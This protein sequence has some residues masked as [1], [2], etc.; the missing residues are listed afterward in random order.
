M[1][2][3]IV[4]TGLKARGY[5]DGRYVGEEK[6]EAG[7]GREDVLRGRK[8]RGKAAGPGT[9][10]GAGRGKKR[11][12]GQA[13]ADNFGNTTA[14][15]RGRRGKAQGQGQAQGGRAKDGLP[16]PGNV[17]A[18]GNGNAAQ[19]PRGAR[20]QPRPQARKNTSG[21]RTPFRKMPM[22]AALA[23]SPSQVDDF[24]RVG[25]EAKSGQ[26]AE[27]LSAQANVK[28]ER[29]HKVMAQS[30]IGSRRDMEIMISTGRVMVNGIVATTGT[31]VS[32][33][34]NVMV[35][36]RPV[37]LKFSEEL[38]RVLLYHKPEG[39]IV[40]TSDPGNRITV[41][42]NLPPVDTGKWIAIGRLDINTSGL[43]IFTTN[44]ELANRFM[45]PRYEVEREYAVRILG[46]LT[47]EQTEALL[48]GVSID[49]NNDEENEDEDEEV[50]QCAPARFDTID[51][52]GGE[53]VNQWYQVTIKE[54]RNREV[55]KMFESQG[56]T[57]SRLIRTRFGKI[58]LPQRLSRG[59]MME[60]SP[61]QV[62][63]ILAGAGMKDEADAALASTPRNA[64]GGKV[65]RERTA[66]GQ[67]AAR[68]QGKGQG[69]GQ[70]QAQ[71]AR[72]KGKGRQQG[73]GQGQ[74]QGQGQ[75]NRP[76]R[77]GNA[78]NA[79]GEQLPRAEGERPRRNRRTGK[80]RRD[81]AAVNTA[82]AGGNAPSTGNYEGF[83]NRVDSGNSVRPDAQSDAQGD[84]HDDRQP[85][86]NTSHDSSGNAVD[87]S[88]GNAPAPAGERG[89]RPPGANPRSR[90]RRNFRT[91]GGRNRGGKREPGEG[92]GNNEGGNSG[93]GTQGGNEGDSRGNRG[94]P[95]NEGGDS[96]GNKGGNSGGNEGGN[97]GGG[98]E[99]NF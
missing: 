31:Q 75:G 32:P 72:G 16:M 36:Q 74:A 73:Q 14:T 9:G 10:A 8:R 1:I 59:K 20:G 63:S 95:G 85:N 53:G 71:Q 97:S 90:Q 33:G 79:N 86:F 22:A 2:K 58:E 3:R 11:G 5:V 47:D 28:R 83:G 62:R 26:F 42:D 87:G 49:D 4:V 38:P 15:K 27:A 52:R 21:K 89:P 66:Q 12:T 44:G 57:V 99:G 6:K 82:N 55:R 67:A 37:K 19:T 18:T 91:R 77:E 84:A 60:L 54:G 93:G 24:R 92:G 70:G 41:F 88:A 25:E 23:P 34:D 29:L 17:G 40:T 98:N 56:L 68:V 94:N 43:L 78:A 45:H 51:K 48:T 65:P 50:V 76:P 81:P 35:D 46:E 61:D 30:G 80:G 69:Q 39:E 13:G 7:A 64:R 96:S